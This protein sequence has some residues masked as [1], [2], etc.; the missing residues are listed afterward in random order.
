MEVFIRDVPEQVTDLG[1]RN[2]LRP[3]MNKQGVKFYHCRKQQ[4]RKIAFLTFL[5]ISDGD[6]FLLA[7]GQEKPPKT[8]AVVPPKI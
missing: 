6:K 5:H 8:G 4:Q 7:N 1:L 3:Y 2:L